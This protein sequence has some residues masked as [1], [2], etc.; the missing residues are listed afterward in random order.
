M[1][2]TE[3]SFYNT[4]HESGEKLR[5][6]IRKAQTQEDK[7]LAFFKSFPEK[8]FTPFDIQYVGVFD[9]SVPLTSIRRAMTNLEKKNFLEKTQ[10]Q[11]EGGFGK[12]NYC[13]RLSEPKEKKFFQEK[14]F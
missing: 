1:I 7:I 12:A 3:T 9:N 2:S 6:S 5:E 11:R 14:L 10:E 13:W 4:I 8:S